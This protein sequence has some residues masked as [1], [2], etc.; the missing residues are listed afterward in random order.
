MQHDE[1]LQRNSSYKSRP[2]LFNSFL[3]L[4]VVIPSSAVKLKDKLHMGE[5]VG[6]ELLMGV[7]KWVTV[8]GKDIHLLLWQME[9][10]VILSN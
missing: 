9:V 10:A 2:K 3:D 8:V 4:P 6:L 5:Q 7:R 1:S